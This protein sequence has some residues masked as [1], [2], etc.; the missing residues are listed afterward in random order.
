MKRG[1]TLVE[2]LA[3]VVILGLVLIIAIPQ[4][5]NEVA[6]KKTAVHET[7]LRMIYDAAELYVTADS[8]T[9]K[10]E[11]GNT[12]CIHLQDLVD[13]ELLEEPITNFQDG[14]ALDLS[15]GIKVVVNEYKEFTYSLQT[16]SS[17]S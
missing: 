3:V 12:Y 2:M 16:T 11:V 13:K 10:K 4:I 9:Y 17:C 1:F 14:S 15:L 6:N 5:Q 7:T 8:H